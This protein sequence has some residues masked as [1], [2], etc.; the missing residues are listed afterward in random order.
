MQTITA[1]IDG[2]TCE[3][4]AQSLERVISNLAKGGI[5]A[6]VDY[7]TGIAKAGFNPSDVNSKEIL[8]AIEAAG[9]EATVLELD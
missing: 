7:T 2:M 9:F 6:T 4:C 3:G 5:V 8:T 1:K